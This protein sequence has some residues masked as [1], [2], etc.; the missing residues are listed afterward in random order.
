MA[1]KSLVLDVDGVLVRDKLLL[2]HVKENCVSY[3]RA[4]LPDAKNP[5]EVNR[6]LHLQLTECHQLQLHVF[7]TTCYVLQRSTHL[8]IN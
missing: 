1:Y 5:R 4:K 6:L 7:E 2:Q 3:V 8:H